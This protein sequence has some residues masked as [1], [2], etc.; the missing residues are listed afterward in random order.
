[1]E[2]P[3]LVSFVEACDAFAAWKLKHEH[4][5]LAHLYFSPEDLANHTCQLGYFDPD[6]QLMISFFVEGDTLIDHKETD[7]FVRTKDPILPLELPS[8]KILPDAALALAKKCQ[9]EKYPNSLP[10]KTFVIIQHLALGQIYNITFVT[11]AFTTLN[12]R[13]ST[14]TGKVLESSLQSLVHYDKG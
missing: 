6:A 2:I 11:R 14:S 3:H 4:S 8:L 9:Q 10:I 7:D 12:I 1:M 5:F 13:L